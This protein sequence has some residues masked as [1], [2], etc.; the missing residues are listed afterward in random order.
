[1]YKLLLIFVVAFQLTGC[2]SVKAVIAMAKSTDHLLSLKEG[3]NIKYEKGTEQ[4]A[5]L[6]SEYLEQAIALLV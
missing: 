4:Y 6:I 5:H 2:T 3:P 1:M